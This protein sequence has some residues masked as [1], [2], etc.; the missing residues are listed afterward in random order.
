MI[1]TVSVGPQRGF[2]FSNLSFS[3]S[4]FFFFPLPFYFFLASASFCIIY[5]SSGVGGILTLFF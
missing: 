3:V 2:S 4:F 1:K 5:I